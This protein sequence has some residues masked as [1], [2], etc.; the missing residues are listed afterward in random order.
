[1]TRNLRRLLPAVL[2]SVGLAAVPAAASAAPVAHALYHMNEAPGATRMLDS[3]GFANNAALV[4]SGITL[5]VPGLS[6]TGYA[7][8]GTGG[9]ASVTSSSLNPGTATVSL[10]AGFNSTTRPSTTVGDYDVLRKGLAGN[11]G[12]YYKMEVL[13]SGV[14]ECFFAS[15]KTFTVASTGVSVV[16]GAWHTI[17]CT[18]TATAISVTVDGRTWSKAVQ[19]G[20]IAN[21]APLTIG[22]KSDGGDTVTGKLDEMAV[23]FG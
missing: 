2:A 7:F 21:T 4:G 17:K 10:V 1:M 11:P 23:Y 12:G 8:A 20:S 15:P 19:I 14:A 13:Q 22:A 5:G 3:S 16:N 9:R 18:K 6:G